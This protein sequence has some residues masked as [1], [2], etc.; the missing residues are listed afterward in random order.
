MAERT[1][2]AA[3]VLRILLIGSRRIGPQASRSFAP[4]RMRT[5]GGAGG[6]AH[7]ADD[8]LVRDSSAGAGSFDARQ[9]D[10]Q[11]AGQSAHGGASGS[12]GSFRRRRV[13]AIG[14]RLDRFGEHEH[15][16][17]WPLAA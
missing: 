13:F 11:F 7:G 8:I 6:V 5:R 15:W 17:T 14:W 3:I 4:V 9:I 12:G 2:L 1:M 16:P 10:A